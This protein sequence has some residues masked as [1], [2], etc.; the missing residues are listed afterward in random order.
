MNNI[1]LIKYLFVDIINESIFDIEVYATNEKKAYKEAL[2]IA[3]DNCTLELI[4]IG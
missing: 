4:K 1:K 2:K 3:R